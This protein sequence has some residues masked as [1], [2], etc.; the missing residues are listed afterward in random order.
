MVNSQLKHELD[1]ME[2]KTHKVE[3]KLNKDIDLQHENFQNLKKLKKIRAKIKQPSDNRRS[4]IGGEI[5]RASG[6]N[7]RGSKYD[8]VVESLGIFEC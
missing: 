3:E 8:D 6:G 7:R 1:S 4:S 2:E 5:R